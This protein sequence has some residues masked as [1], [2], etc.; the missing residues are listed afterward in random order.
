MLILPNHIRQLN[1]NFFPP[2]GITSCV[3][4]ILMIPEPGVLYTIVLNVLI[5]QLFLFPTLIFRLSL[6]VLGPSMS[7]IC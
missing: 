5:F 3:I 4:T 2:F 1:H 7:H 6:K